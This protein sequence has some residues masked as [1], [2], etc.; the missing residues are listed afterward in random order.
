MAL[1]TIENILYEGFEEERKELDTKLR[2][3][4]E[5]YEKT[6]AKLKEAHLLVKEEVLA[7]Y[8]I[9]RDKH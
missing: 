6:V 9:E 7:R 8:R 4:D 1:K 5:K 2:V 3:I